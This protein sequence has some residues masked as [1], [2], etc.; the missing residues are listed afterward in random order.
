MRHYMFKSFNLLFS[1]VGRL[2]EGEYPWMLDKIYEVFNIYLFI[3]YGI[4]YNV[5]KNLNTWFQK[6]W[7][8]IFSS[9]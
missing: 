1:Q 7:L 2:K 9:L 4:K 8:K 6:S 3:S 5:I